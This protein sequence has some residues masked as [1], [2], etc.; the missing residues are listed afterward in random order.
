VWIVPQNLYT[1]I[2]QQLILLKESVAGRELL[3]FLETKMVLEIIR[4]YGYDTPDVK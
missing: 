4:Q 1:P 3:N 2:K